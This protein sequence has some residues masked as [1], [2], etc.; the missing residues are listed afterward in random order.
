MQGRIRAADGVRGLFEVFSGLFVGDRRS[1]RAVMEN[2]AAGLAASICVHEEPENPPDPKSGTEFY[3]IPLR[4]G[5]RCDPAA[6][7]ETVE[8]VA[9]HRALGHRT[10]VYCNAGCSRSPSVLAAYMGLYQG[11]AVKAMMARPIVRSI[12]AKFAFFHGWLSSDDLCEE[13]DLFPVE[14]RQDP[15]FQQCADA[16]RLMVL[17]DPDVYMNPGLWFSVF[18]AIRERGRVLH[19]TEQAQQI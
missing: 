2:P 3:H 1:A 15:L 5:M 18:P 12:P 17:R 7:L 13:D 8:I 19:L 10:L 9:F 16:F 4:D 11:H 6:F 14:F